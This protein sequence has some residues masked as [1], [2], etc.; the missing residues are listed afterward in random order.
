MQEAANRRF[1]IVIPVTLLIVILLLV[2]FHDNQKEM[3]L[4]FSNIPFSIV[5]GI[6]SLYIF[7]QD[8]SIP[9]IIGFIALFGIA[10]QDTLV[11]INRIKYLREKGKDVLSAT[12]EGSVSKVRPVMMTTMTTAFAL[13]PLIFSSGIGAEIQRP[14]A[15]VVVGGLLSST[16][17]TLF[18]VPTFYNWIFGNND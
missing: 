8:L 6:I 14:L 16:V 17:L 3:L 13:I 5:G 15:I 4:I 2:A 18:I 9:S 12:I 10:L 7:K 1:R 11:L